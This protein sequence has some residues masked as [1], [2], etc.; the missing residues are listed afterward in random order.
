MG[1][2]NRR[3]D[4]WRDNRSWRDQGEYHYWTWQPNGNGWPDQE[5][6]EDWYGCTNQNSGQWSKRDKVQKGDRTRA[7]KK[8]KRPCEVDEEEAKLQAAVK[9]INK[10]AKEAREFFELEDARREQ[11]KR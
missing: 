2:Q 11:R 7:Q 6:E 10:Q 9:A 4:G 1:W 3:E 5:W 8:D